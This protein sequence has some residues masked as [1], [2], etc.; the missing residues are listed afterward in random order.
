[1]IQAAGTALTETLCLRQQHRQNNVNLV[2]N[3]NGR[4]HGKR[5]LHETAGDGVE[6][7]N[8][9]GGSL[10]VTSCEGDYAH[11]HLT[12]TVR[13]RLLLDGQ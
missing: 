6:F 13:A 8:F 3:F 1:M 11:Q 4:R 10:A 5:S 9:N 2:V 12:T 7:V